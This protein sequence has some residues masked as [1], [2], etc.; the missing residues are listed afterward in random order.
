[1]K[2]SRH[3][4]RTGAARAC[5]ASVA[6]VVLFLIAGCAS[7]DSIAVIPDVTN[8]PA[9]GFEKVASG[10]EQD[11]ILHVGRRTY[12]TE[13]SAELDDTA[14]RTLDAQARW[15]QGHPR[16]FV[17]LQGHA[18]DPGNEDANREISQ[19]RAEAVMSYLISQGVPQSRLWAKGYGRERLVRNCAD[20]ECKAQNRRV[21]SN[22]RLQ[23]DESAPDWGSRRIQY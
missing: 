5:T 8:A 3:S 7:V 9:Q 14:K 11:F 6:L 1:M 12:F 17:K 19:R 23:K 22:L 2:P 15:L 18:D 21:V 10:S 4:R 16:W 13:K 20:I